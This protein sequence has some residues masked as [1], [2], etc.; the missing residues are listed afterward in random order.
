[1][2]S[3]LFGTCA[4]HSYALPTT[5]PEGQ[6]KTDYVQ[7]SRQDFNQLQSQI[8]QLQ[9]ALNDLAKKSGQSSQKRGSLVNAVV[10]A[11][12]FSALIILLALLVSMAYVFYDY[13]FT[14]KGDEKNKNLGFFNY[15]L[16]KFRY[17]YKVT[18]ENKEEVK[19]G[20]MDTWMR[21]MQVWLK[22]I[23]DLNIQQMYKGLVPLLTALKDGKIFDYMLDNFK[24]SYGKKENQKEEADGNSTDE[25]DKKDENVK[26]ITLRELLKKPQHLFED[27]IK[28]L[29]EAFGKGDL[30]NYLLDNWKIGNKTL[31]VML[32]PILKLLGENS[33]EAILNFK[34]TVKNNNGEKE[35]KTIKELFVAPILEYITAYLGKDEKGGRLESLESWKSKFGKMNYEK[36]KNFS[37][38]YQNITSESLKNKNAQQIMNDIKE[39]K[40]IQDFYE[41]LIGKK[42]EG[43]LNKSENL[44]FDCTEMIKVILN[45]KNLARKFGN[46]GGILSAGNLIDAFKNL[47]GLETK[48][49]LRPQNQFSLYKMVVELRNKLQFRLSK[50]QIE[51][52]KKAKEEKQL[53][54]SMF[55]G[56]FLN[57]IY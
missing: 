48:A 30:L 36:I 44:L 53:E 2:L 42:E 11:V 25:E 14:F 26:T 13:N 19:I 37:Q 35:E 28:K 39:L 12:Y 41:E 24:F 47:G 46:A 27:E 43:I 17:E 31:R 50:M 45:D 16:S 38:I 22:D 5:A 15:L 8:A 7:I 20:D 3:F 51:V 23:Q 34:I 40:K 6:A 1:M 18:E 49:Q 56:S 29:I 4:S 57:D 32:D 10:G 55:I 21:D 33:L 54:E 52:E 9:N